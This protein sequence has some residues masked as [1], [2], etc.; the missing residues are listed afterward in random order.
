MLL[1]PIKVLNWW[2]IANIA[3]S[4]YRALGTALEWP[5]AKQRAHQVREWGIEVRWITTLG[6]RNNLGL[7]ELAIACYLEQ[8]KRKGEGCSSLG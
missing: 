5:E 3:C 4:F 7:M 2:T 1:F 8:S 6:F